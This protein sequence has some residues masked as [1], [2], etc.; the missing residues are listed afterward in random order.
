MVHYKHYTEEALIAGMQCRDN[1]VLKYVH[2]HFYPTISHLVKSNNGSELDA[3]DIFQD[4]VIIIFE[5]L[6]NG[7]LELNCSFKTYLYS[8]S[9]NLWMQSLEK[10]RKSWIDITNYVNFFEHKRCISSLYYEN[11]KD[12][13]FHKHFLSLSLSCQ[14]ILNL[15]FNKTSSEKIAEIMG[16]SSGQYARKRKSQCRKILIRRIHNDPLYKQLKKNEI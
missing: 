12:K 10:K 7:G 14:K 1:D 6:Q 16:F 15:M 11:Q 8:I 2:Q 5:Q 3:E 13:L 9:R 4:A